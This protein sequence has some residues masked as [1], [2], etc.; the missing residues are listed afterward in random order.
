M[1][2]YDSQKEKHI[3][4]LLRALKNNHIDLLKWLVDEQGVEL[5]TEGVNLDCDDGLLEEPV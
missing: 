3:T 1:T 5:N 2:A 4:P